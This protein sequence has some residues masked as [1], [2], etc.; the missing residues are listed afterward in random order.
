MPEQSWSTGRQTGRSRWW[1]ALAAAVIAFAI[2]LS[3]GA[4]L[5]SVRMVGDGSEPA[6]TEAPASGRI[7]NVGATTQTSPSATTSAPGTSRLVLIGPR[8]V[9]DSRPGHR[10]PAGAEV[11][12]PLT[13]VPGDSSAVLLE[14]SVLNA[15]EGGEVTLVS[16]GETTSVLK[17]PGSGAQTSATVVARLGADRG[18]AARVAGGGDL[19]VTV[20]G[21]FEPATT[22]AAGRIVAVPA[23]QA[24]ELVPGRDGNRA[25]IRFDQLALDGTPRAEV[26]AL[27][28][29]FQADVGVHGGTVAV[30]RDWNHLDQQAYWAATS[31]SDR[32]RRAFLVVPLSSDRLRLYY[33]AGTRLI[34]DVVGLVTGPAAA[35]SSAGL[36]VPVAPATQ[37]PV[38][39]PAGG[40]ADVDL[41]DAGP[42]KAAL[43]TTV[44]T[45]KGGRSRAVLGLLDVQGG[46][47]RLN[48]PEQAVV[49]V[50]PRLLIR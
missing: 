29:S 2:V 13:G 28:L 9:V 36:S 30:G 32:T 5:L 10:L 11:N 49:T 23:E 19:V 47:V 3:S 43:V 33:H 45:P 8:R 37:P 18:L 22:A 12:V 6:P 39:L 27:L 50:T 31:S 20:T 17:V 1:S 38:T 26:G 40:R 16:G 24:L 35:T 7:T 41:P 15:R 46:A 34:V 44:T 48:G 14:V 25:T 4:V 42:A 21:A